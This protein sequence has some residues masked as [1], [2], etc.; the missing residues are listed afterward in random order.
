[1]TDIK[2]GLMTLKQAAKRNCV[3]LQAIYIA[4]RKKTLK[5]NRIGKEWM[6]HEDDLH[7]YNK[8]RYSRTKSKQDGQLVYDHLAGNY[9]PMQ[10][11]K[12]LKKPVQR[13][14]YLM[15]TGHIK[16]KKVGNVYVI[17]IHDVKR[18][19]ESNEKLEI[20]IV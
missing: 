6:I 15:R 7:L 20:K 4:I 5:A 17:N 2:D 13:I 8:T 1:M 12:L 19:L 16:N 11:S 14:Y 9:S 18:Y 3:T 10:L